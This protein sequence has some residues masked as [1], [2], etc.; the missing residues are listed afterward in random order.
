MRC[1]FWPNDKAD[2][3]RLKKKKSDR[4]T[5]AQPEPAPTATWLLTPPPDPCRVWAAVR[6][7]ALRDGTVLRLVEKRKAGQQVRPFHTRTVE[8]KM[9]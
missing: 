1:V 7:L 6:L 4:A 8:N 3:W 5:D 9:C 2:Q